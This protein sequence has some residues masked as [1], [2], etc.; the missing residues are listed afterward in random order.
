MNYL[1]KLFQNQNSNSADNYSDIAGTFSNCESLQDNFEIP[2]PE[3]FN[4]ARD[5]VDYYAQVEPQKRALVWC[6]DDGEEKIF[7]F[8]DISRESKKTAQFLIDSGISKGDVVMLM[9]RRRYEFWYFIL[10]CHR[11]GAIAVPATVQLTSKDIE[12][13]VKTSGAKMIV[14][15][16]DENVNKEIDSALENFARAGIASD[17]SKKVDA[18]I[19]SDVSK[20]ARAVIKKDFGSENSICRKITLSQFHKTFDNT[21]LALYEIPP[22]TKNSDTMVVFFTSG[23][24]GE[25]KMVAHNFLYPLGHIVTA[26]FWQCTV[27][28]GLHLTLAETGW[29]K[30]VWGKLYGQWIC[31]SAVFVYDFITFKPGNVLEKIEKYKVTTFC[32]PPTIYRY[33]IRTDFSKHDITSLTHCT[34]AGESLSEEVS[35]TFFKKTNLKIH[36]AYGQT[37]ATVII[38][39]F[40]DSETKPGSMG[41]ASPCYDVIIENEN[42]DECAPN[43]KGQVVVKLDKKIPL[44]LFSGYYNDEEKTR[45]VFSDK[46]YY[47]GDTAYCDE[48]G[49]FFYCGRGDDVI[50]SAGFRISPYEV[51]KVLASHPAVMECLVCGAPDEKRG[52]VVKAMIVLNDGFE[53]GE[54]LAR[55]IQEYVFKRIALYKRPRVVEFVKSLPKTVSDKIVR[56]KA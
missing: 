4:F 29:A 33:L 3:N 21:N 31:G 44:G 35:E 11:I 23:T 52:Q 6:N 24:S 53:P 1:K 37:E 51:E 12:Y 41:K 50:K 19:T 36:E 43:E 10:A 14:T 48:D 55:E 9:L 2:T 22:E 5:V 46:K 30:A 45:A 34:T 28:D 49:Y 42:G 56:K 8:E 40:F 26:L 39:N 7:S 18:G 20:E 25:P 15:I 47:T 32:A 13:R 38:G 16:D 27:D 17:V 54:T